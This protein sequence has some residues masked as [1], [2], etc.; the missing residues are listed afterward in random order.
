V[1]IIPLYLKND[2]Q[3]MSLSPKGYVMR[4]ILQEGPINRAAIAKRT[5]LSI[6]SVMT[7]T[8]DLISRGLVQA[9]GKGESRGGKRPELLSVVPESEYYIGVDIG[10]GSV[11]LVILNLSRNV[12]YGT[13][14]DTGE[15]HPE[16]AFAD[17]LCALILRSIEESGVDTAKLVGIG[18]AMPGLIE[19]ETGHVLFSPDFD[20][21][22]IPLQS[23]L[24]RKLPYPVLVE[25]ANRAL[26]LAESDDTQSTGKQAGNSALCV[27]IGHGIGAALV[28]DGRLYYGSSGTSGEIGHITVSKD[29]P[30][31]ACGNS[32]CLEAMASG[33]AIAQQARD[34]VRSGIPTALRTL[35]EH[36][37][38][39]I[40][41]KMVFDAA[42]VGD[43]VAL[44]IVDKATDYI[45]IGLAMAINILDPD[46]IV[47]CGGLTKNGPAFFDR[48]VKSTSKRQMRQAGRHVTISVGKKGDYGTAIGAALIIPYNG[49]R[50]PALQ[51]LY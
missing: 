14:E 16:E 24:Q 11:R 27:N 13:K 2:R 20:W 9:V 6:P 22:D 31:C 30:L 4:C 3:K 1:V 51:H 19:Q 18:I 47:L 23:W 38:E 40:N 46:R 10:R 49:W 15:V 41:A 25:N 28:Q 45:G 32:G 34:A 39:N 43:M 36:S 8:D 17:R 7:I 5:S 33:D 50:V 44:S 26:A 29:G 12:V 21:N 35:C 48:V 37:L 42:A